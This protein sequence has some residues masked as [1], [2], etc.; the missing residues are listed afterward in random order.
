M[1]KENGAATFARTKLDAG[2]LVKAE[3]SCG[4]CDEVCELEGQSVGHCNSC[5]FHCFSL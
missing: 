5:V 2:A 4:L 1:Q 3:L